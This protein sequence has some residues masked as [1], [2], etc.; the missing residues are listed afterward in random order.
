MKRP[1][2]LLALTLL[3]CQSILT[4]RQMHPLQVKEVPAWVANAF[5]VAQTQ[6][7]AMYNEVMKTGLLPRSIRTGITTQNRLD[8][9][10]LPRYV[11]V[12]VHLHRRRYMENTC[13]KSHR[14]DGRRTEQCFRP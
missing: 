3:S 6:S 14:L 4:A 1:V 12:S 7:E 13:R 8:G 10:L 11:M 9:R 2:L 5:T